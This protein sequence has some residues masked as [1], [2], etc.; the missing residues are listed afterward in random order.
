MDESTTER[1]SRSFGARTSTLLFFLAMEGDRSTEPAELRHIRIRFA[2]RCVLCGV[3]LPVRTEAL[4]DSRLKT[5]RC[6]SCPTD[7]AGRIGAPIDVGMAGGSAGREY[8]R[9]VAARDARVRSRFGRRLGGVILALTD[10]PQSTRA[11]ARGSQ[12]EQ[13]LADALARVDGVRVL[14]DR[15]VPGTRGNIDHLVIAA[16]GVFVVDAKRY[17]GT[18]RVR[19]VGGLFRTDK[20]LFVGRRDCSKLADNMGWQVEVV[21]QVLGSHRVDPMPPITPVLCFV[22]GEWPLLSPPSSFRGVRL[23]GTRSIQRLIAAPQVQDAAAV[24]QLT[25]VLAAALPAK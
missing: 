23:E 8:E 1:R 25:R 15:R 7:Q 3:E 2:G 19:D 12:G 13:D 11:W 17:D 9:R 24:D 22:K 20:R 4:Y 6:V 14:H 16:A 18:I 10:E 21:Q 5:V